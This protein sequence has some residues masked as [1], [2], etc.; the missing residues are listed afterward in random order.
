MSDTQWHTLDG[1]ADTVKTKGEKYQEIAEAI[2]RA[3]TTLDQI[4]DDATT[5]AQSMD[6]TKSLASDVRE[7][8]K[9]AT[10]RYQVTGDALVAYAP[11]L[12][13]AITSS[14]TAARR[15][16][17]LEDDLVPARQRAS[18]AQWEMDGM[19]GDAPDTDVDDAKSELSNANDRV[20]E[21]ETSLTYWQGQWTSARDDKNTAATTAKDQIDEVVT[22]D[23]VNGL[24]DST[25]D[26]IKHVAASLYKVF[27]VICDIAGILAIFLSWVPI[28]GQILVVLAAIGSILSILETIVS[29]AKGEIGWGGLLLGVGLGVV[30]LFGGKLA[31]SLGKVAKA[32]AVTKAASLTNS[33]SRLAVRLAGNADD[34]ARMISE[35]QTTMSNADNLLSMKTILSSPFKRSDAMDN[36][37]QLRKAGNLSIAEGLKGAAKEAFVMPFKDPF[38]GTGELFRNP[39]LY[40][41]LDGLAGAAVTTNLVNFGAASFNAGRSFAEAVGGDDGWAQVNSSVGLAGPLTDGPYVQLAQIPGNVASWSDTFDKMI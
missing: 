18:N 26:K 29:F 20:T 14:E 36:L 30:G 12:S 8:I 40:H 28:L 9:K 13:A 24:E 35:A 22:G 21:L 7:D 17:E 23:K 33:Q 19:R 11:L 37:F 34:G 38:G 10:D 1:N 25:W 41:N 27:K 31:S 3:L 32:R 39:A 2:T 4:V 15:I 5:T 6:A 16:A